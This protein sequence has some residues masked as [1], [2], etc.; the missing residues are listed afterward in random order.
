MSEAEIKML[1]GSQ[2]M[3]TLLVFFRN[4]PDFHRLFHCVLLV[5]MCESYNAL[6][7]DNKLLAVS[8][9]WLVDVT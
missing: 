6:K 2:L 8:S 4:L 9:F 1:K 3:T 7:F 5:L